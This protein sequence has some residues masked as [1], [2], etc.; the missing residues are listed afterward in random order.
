M[1]IASSPQRRQRFYKFSEQAYGDRRVDQTN[2]DSALLRLLMVVRDVRTRWNSTH[3]MLA[4]ALLLREVSPS[5][6]SS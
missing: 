3:S 1:K 4:R 2:K 5:V 6:T